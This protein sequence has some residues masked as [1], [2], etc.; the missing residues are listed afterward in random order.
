M[1]ASPVLACPAHAP[2]SIPPPAIQKEAGGS[3]LRSFGIELA[4]H[5]ELP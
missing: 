4:W 1:H 2:I 3:L 5:P